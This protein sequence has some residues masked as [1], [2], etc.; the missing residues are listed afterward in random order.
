MKILVINENVLVA[1]PDSSQIRKRGL[2]NSPD[3]IGPIINTR[4][5]T[6]L[7]FDNSI[8]YLYVFSKS[9]IFN[10]LLYQE[11]DVLFKN[12][13]HS[14]LTVLYWNWVGVKMSS[15]MSHYI[16]STHTIRGEKSTQTLASCF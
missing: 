13:E 5:K 8:G 15:S 1:R 2:K 7:K 4:F 3:K 14:S 12:D 6:K 16:H 9:I 10:I 11:F